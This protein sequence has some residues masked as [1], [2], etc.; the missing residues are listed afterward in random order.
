MADPITFAQVTEAMNSIPHSEFNTLESLED[1]AESLGIA[2][3]VP[4]HIESSI[5]R[6]HAATYIIAMM[7]MAKVYRDLAEVEQAPAEV[8]RFLDSLA[9]PEDD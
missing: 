2:R 4:A 7:T 3:D 8:D 9:K 1:L 6:T 5:P